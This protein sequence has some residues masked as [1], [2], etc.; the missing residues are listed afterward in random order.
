VLE[1]KHDLAAGEFLSFDYRGDFFHRHVPGSVTPPGYNRVRCTCGSNAV[2]P[3][4]LERFENAVGQLL[5]SPRSSAHHEARR[6]TDR[7]RRTRSSTAALWSSQC[8]LTG[9]WPIRDQT[10][11]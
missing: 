4:D 9:R 5:L 2:C 6:K 10:G 3:N 1:A 8:R 11:F 7:P